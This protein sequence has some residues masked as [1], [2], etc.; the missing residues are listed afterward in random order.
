MTTELILTK[1]NKKQ[2]NEMADIIEKNDAQYFAD[3]YGLL[4]TM[5]Y[6]SFMICAFIRERIREIGLWGYS[7]ND[8]IVQKHI[9]L[10]YIRDMFEYNELPER[11]WIGDSTAEMLINTYL[12]AFLHDGKHV[13]YDE[14][15]EVEEKDGYKIISGD[16]CKF[17]SKYKG[18]DLYRAWNIPENH[19][20]MRYFAVKDD[21][22][23]E[24]KNLS[25]IKDRC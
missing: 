14:C 2:A 15:D 17:H 3:H 8:P 5:K 6:F 24:A 1:V 16:Y 18:W 23:R 22:I 10:D 9:N 4:W 21:E 11:L 7:M 20:K 25:E 13:D 19:G 12:L